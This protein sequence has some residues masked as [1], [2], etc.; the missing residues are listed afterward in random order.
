M[1]QFAFAGG[2]LGYGDQR[3]KSRKEPGTWKNSSDPYALAVSGPLNLG[4][5]DRRRGVLADGKA[6][7]HATGQSWG[8]LS[9]SLL[10]LLFD[11]FF[12]HQMNHVVLFCNGTRWLTCGICAFRFHTNST[13]SFRSL[14]SEPLNSSHIIALVT[15]N[16]NTQYNYD[17]RWISIR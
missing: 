2:C 1:S 14:T 9:H 11:I 4:I 12:N 13:I 3:E 10:S 16:V 6:V 7:R 17:V 15:A 8:S 5:A